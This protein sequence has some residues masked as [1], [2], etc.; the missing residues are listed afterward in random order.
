MEQQMSLDFTWEF[1]RKIYSNPEEY[2]ICHIPRVCFHRDYRENSV[3][4]FD[5]GEN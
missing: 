5:V 3:S 4:G 2:E 1:E